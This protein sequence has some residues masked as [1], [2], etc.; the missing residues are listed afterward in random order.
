MQWHRVVGNE[1]T[2]SAI[3]S[4]CEKGREWK[5]AG[6]LMPLSSQRDTIT[7]SAL[8][9]AFQKADRWE[10]AFHQLNLMPLRRVLPNAFS[11]NS[12]IGS[13][14]DGCW[15]Q[16]LFMLR[17]PKFTAVIDEISY[18]SVMMSICEE[19]RQWKIALELL[20]SMG[21]H[22]IQPDEVSC[23]VVLTIFE[24]I[25]QWQVS[26][27]SLG[28]LKALGSDSIAWTSAMTAT[29]NWQ[30]P[31]PGVRVALLLLYR[32]LQQDVPPDAPFY[33][34]ALE[35]CAAAKRWQIA[36]QLLNELG[37]DDV[38]C[39][40]ATLV[41]CHG[42][43]KFISGVAQQ[44]LQDRDVELRQLQ[45]Q[46]SRA[47]E[48]WKA[49]IVKLVEEMRK[50]EQKSQTLIKELAVSK[51]ELQRLKAGGQ[52]VV[53]RYEEESGRRLELEERCLQLEEKLK[54]REQRTRDASDGAQKL[55][56]C[57]QAKQLAEEKAKE[58]EERSRE[59][60]ERLDEAN[61]RCSQLEAEVQRL[62]I[63]CAEKSK[64]IEQLEAAPAEMESS[65]PSRPPIPRSRPGTAS[66]VGSAGAGAGF[67][68]AE[69]RDSR[70]SRTQPPPFQSHGERLPPGA[71]RRGGSVPVR[72]SQ[73][74]PQRLTLQSRSISPNASASQRTDRSEIAA[75]AGSFSE[76]PKSRSSH[77]PSEDGFD[78]AIP[79][80][81]D[82]S[83]EEVLTGVNAKK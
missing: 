72:R 79:T 32:A 47:E 69:G 80:S 44:A 63:Q 17:A 37:G 28:T 78:D 22:S 83:D 54:S 57:Q 64:R 4:A 27:Q 42:A 45:E 67:P 39:M 75:A 53:R 65:C 3:I 34:A 2:Y 56:Q 82:S 23:S 59:S 33:G 20:S 10:G 49:Q 8:L 29:K 77:T 55:K 21:Q 1:L 81:D 50:A 68:R 6:T 7:I 61:V 15:A 31:W 16:P 51:G 36:V 18:N 40:A 13:S 58:H 35:S 9:S 74:V 73:G 70:D 12:V 11:I 76:R 60:T 19:V 30:V 14:C 52:D 24:R 41:A 62:R 46:H 38:V 48:Q 25:K 26:L 71:I 5:L 66:S 43:M